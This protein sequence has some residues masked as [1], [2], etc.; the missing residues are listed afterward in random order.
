MKGKLLVNIYDPKDMMRIT[1]VGKVYYTCDWF[2]HI[3][4]VSL[5]SRDLMRQ[6][7][8]ATD[9]DIKL[10]NKIQNTKILNDY[11]NAIWDIC[12][13]IERLDKVLKDT[14]YLEFNEQDLLEN[15]HS[16]LNDLKK[17]MEELKKYEK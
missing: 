11:E 9:E 4:K 16:T 14:Q 3:N 7:R 8:F 5:S 15:I 13:T 10:Y 6:Y 1:S 2:Y 12:N 17:D